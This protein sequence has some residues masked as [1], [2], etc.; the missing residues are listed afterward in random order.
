[1]K[2]T[3]MELLTSMTCTRQAKISNYSLKNEKKF[4]LKKK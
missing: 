2:E 1:M 4:N 3:D